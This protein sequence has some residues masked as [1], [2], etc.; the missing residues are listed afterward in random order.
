MKNEIIQNSYI[1]NPEFILRDQAIALADEFRQHALNNC[2]GDSQAPDSHAEYDFMPFVRLLVK[3]VPEVSVLVGEDV[4]PTYVY[5]RV[6]KNGSILNRHK[7]RAAC[8]VSLTINLLKSHD[9]PIYFQRP[10][11][12]ETS[13]ELEPGDAVL[14]LGCTADHWRHQFNGDEYTQMFLHYVC[15]NGKNSWAYFDKNRAQVNI[16]EWEVNVL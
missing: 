8:E 7:D 11:G 9:W 4:L 3:K 14:Y 16:E 6:Y 2:G 10:D 15:A 1:R 12:S 5:A 13:V